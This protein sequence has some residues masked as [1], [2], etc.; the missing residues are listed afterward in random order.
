MSVSGCRRAL[1]LTS[2]QR[3]RALNC[4]P[5]LNLLDFK[6]F[7]HGGI[8]R[9]CKGL[10]LGFLVCKMTFGPTVH[11]CGKCALF[12]H[13]GGGSALL[14]S[15]EFAGEGCQLV[16][17][18]VNSD[19]S[20]SVLVSLIDPFISSRRVN[21]QQRISWLGR[22]KRQRRSLLPPRVHPMRWCKLR[23]GRCRGESR[24][25]SLLHQRR[26]EQAGALLCCRRRPV[27]RRFRLTDRLSNICS[28]DSAL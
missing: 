18:G 14:T 7:V 19:I 28:K 11:P 27:C 2:W 6:L 13:V 4:V 3:T 17:S 15:Q 10:G 25:H 1:H 21:L 20:S 9:G 26:P 8:L 12:D 22:R 5:C 16:T 24:Q 23:Q